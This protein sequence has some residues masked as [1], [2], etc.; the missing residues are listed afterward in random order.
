M[1]RIENASKTFKNKNGDFKALKNVSLSIKENE[2]FGIVGYSGAGKSTLIRVINQLEN[3]DEGSIYVNDVDVTKLS[4]KNLLTLRQ[5]IGMIFQHFN[6]LWSSTVLENIALPLEIIHQDKTSRLNKAKELAKLVGLEDKINS[7]PATLSGGQKQRVA[8]ARA[9]ATNPKII[10]CDEATSALDPETTESILMLLKDIN[11]KYGITIVLITHQL[12]VVQ[13]ICHR[14]AFM[15]GG[16]IVE[17]GTVAEIFKKPKQLITK[18][19]IDKATHSNELYKT[20]LD[21][22]NIYQSGC[23]L[24]IKFTDEQTNQPI[25]FNLCK[26]YNTPFSVVSASIIHSQKAPLGVLSVHI[27]KE[28]EEIKE[29]V[30]ELKNK[31]IEVEVYE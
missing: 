8:I 24:N 30:S 1:I 5:N 4:N 22:K 28:F 3:V 26:K 29:L 9:L 20:H 27:E 21:L 10:L 16:E 25:L 15:S 11:H 18:N 13:K 14:V 31:G 19:F 2:I 17:V 12:E 7:Y 6:L 23:L